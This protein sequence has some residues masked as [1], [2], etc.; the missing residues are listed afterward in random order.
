MKRDAT[1]G[2]NTDAS[3]RRFSLLVVEAVW[4]K[5]QEDPVFFS[6]RHDAC[7]APIS[8]DEYGK[9]TKCGWEVD[10]VRPVSA[11]GSD[12]IDNLQPLHWE[13]NRHKGDNWPDFTCKRKS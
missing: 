4:R 10:H 6:F 9:T 11:D 1:R 3:G 5:A 13:N 7:G 2:P 12:G 8:R